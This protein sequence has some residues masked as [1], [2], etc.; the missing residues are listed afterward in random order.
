MKMKM[1]W[2][3]LK[4]QLISSEY[5]YFHTDNGVLLC[6]DCIEIMK[7]LPKESVDLI[8]T[9]PPY[10]ISKEN[11]FS[12]MRNV[13]VGI[14]FGE[15]DKNFDLFSWLD[16]GISLLNKNG[17]MFIF[18]AWKNIGNIAM[19]AEEKGMEAKDCFRWEKSNPMPRNR[20]RR[21]IVDYEFGVW[22]VKKKAK[23]IF[24]RQNEKF[25]R[26]KFISSVTGGKERTK[27][28]TQKP[29]SLMEH[30]LKIH[31]NE[32][33]IVLDP[34]MGSGTTAIASEKTNR[35]WIGIELSEEYCEITKDRLVKTINDKGLFDE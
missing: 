23:W 28:P 16:Y 29:I 26:P 1:N 19:Y 31:S 10:N 20:D 34:F 24:N 25:E 14:D 13:R 15:W 11:N 17:S 30:L 6:G 8:L 2:N 7:K 12:T 21:Y 27:H 5:Y 9:D 33:E 35:K 3:K 32:N 4:E 18:N 22:L